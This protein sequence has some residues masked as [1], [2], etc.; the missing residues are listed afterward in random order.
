H[1][2]DHDAVRRHCSPPDR[3]R[4]GGR[5]FSGGYCHRLAPFRAPA[6][7]RGRAHRRLRREHSMDIVILEE[8]LGGLDEVKEALDQ[9]ITV[10][11]DLVEE[12]DP[13]LVPHLPE[14]LDR[15]LLQPL[16]AH[17]AAVEGCVA[18]FA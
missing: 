13:A 1:P 2:S 7:A 8:M 18:N 3:G 11:T 4:A 15:T 17:R 14:V 9:A 16:T 10:L 12:C 5:R 6:C